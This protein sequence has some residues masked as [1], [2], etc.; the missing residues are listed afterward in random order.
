[1]ASVDQELFGQA[2]TAFQTG[3]LSD[4]EHQFKALLQRQPNHV[5][6][7]NLLSVLLTQ[8]GR[9]SEAEAYI[10]R[11][12]QLN[13]TSDAS[14]YNYGL[15]LK[16][17]RRP[18][19]ALACFD[20]ALAL[21]HGVAQTWNNRG[22]VLNDLKRYA[23]AIIDFE[24]AIEL[25]PNFPETH[26]NRA[27]SFASLRRY[28]EAIVA[29]DRALKLRPDLAEAWLG[30]G[31]VCNAL[32]RYAEAL[33]AYERALA[34][35]PNF[36][37][38]WVGRGNTYKDLARYDEA[39][40]CYNKAKQLQPDLADAWVGNGN[41]YAA[42]QQ[43]EHALHSYNKA[44]DLQSNLAEA[45]LGCGNVFKALRRYSEALDAYDKAIAHKADLG[46]AWLGRGA[47]LIDL[48]R[49]EEALLAFD[50]ALTIDPD[51]P[52]AEG[53]RLHTKLHL[54]D[55]LNYDNDRA[56]LISAIR[57]GKPNSLPFDFLGIADSPADQLKCAT[58]AIARRFPP[59]AT[60]VWRGEHYKH[61]KIRV[62]Y[63][64]ADFRQHVVS[65][66]LAGVFECHD[67]S[68]F[69]VTAFSFGPSD[70]SDLRRRLEAAFDR[71]VD[72]QRD[73]ESQVTQRIRSLE[74]DILVDLMGITADSRPGILA[75]RPAPIQVSFL[76]YL[77][78]M[79]APYINYIIGDRIVI[80][81]EQKAFYKEEVIYLPHCFQP[82]DR[83]RS[84]ANKKFSRAEAGLPSEGFVFCNFNTNYKITPVVFDRWM[85][86]L[87]RVDG[88]VLWLVVEN[89]IAQQNL[90]REAAAR[91][92]DPDRLIFAPKLPLHEH[93]AR[94][95]AADLFLDSWPYN[96]G[97]TASDTLWVGV[98]L[99][100][101][102]GE[103]FVGRMAASVLQ[104]IGL[105]ELVTTTADEYEALAIDLATNTGRLDAIKEKLGRNRL[106]EPL[107]DTK[108]YTK[109]IEAAYVEMYKVFLNKKA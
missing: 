18:A 39:A 106:T 24:K 83:A 19:D 72:V 25:E 48:R 38:A 66:L 97:A 108:R 67:R 93:Q 34:L 12:L 11:A 23:E 80:P 99:L 79:G 89:Q 85:R 52:G 63:F 71:F 37:D 8:L 57:A 49:Y 40:S 74:I 86:I 69:E 14:F 20:K 27:R 78:T 51:F 102:L 15:I 56:Q 13:S 9:F 60:P 35:K 105:P 36:S 95:R 10:K 88:S 5:P 73:S 59:A 47:L 53:A 2:L 82:T 91:G 61:D 68:R 50:R 31:G 107:F 44:I 4:S 62:G 6:A 75:Q 21:N 43:Y 84:V 70:N 28:D 46:E 32:R 54:C 94:V 90:I 100:T 30:R 65:S 64:S 33:A 81:E 26:C 77:G 58:L 87:Q 3:R 101:L 45:W 109:D 98:P 55:W 42:L 104:A 92:V 76:G 1:M 41:V 7:L 22:V 17:L 29:Y 96:A 16:A 103:T